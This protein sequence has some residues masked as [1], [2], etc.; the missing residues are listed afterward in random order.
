MR[1]ILLLLLLIELPIFDS[2][3][4]WGYSE[5]ILRRNFREEY[6]E[7]LSKI[8]RFNRIDPKYLRPG[9]KIKI[10]NNIDLLDM[11]SPLPVYVV[12]LK[13][14]KVI[15][16]NL[17]EQWGGA[18]E[19]GVLQFSFPISSAD[20]DCVDDYGRKE[21]CETPEGDFKVLGFD[22]D[23][24]SSLYH[25]PITGENI[26]MPYA[27]L[28]HIKHYK[29]F[30]V[31]YWLHG[32]KLPGYPA[33][34]GCVRLMMEDIKRLF[35]WAGG[36]VK[37]R[38]FIKAKENVFVKV[39]NSP[40]IY[41]NQG[42]LTTLE[43]PY[44]TTKAYFDERELVVF[45][46]DGKKYVLISTNIDERIGKHFLKV[47]Q[48]SELLLEKLIII[49]PTEFSKNISTIWGRY[50]LD[51]EKLERIRK[52]KEAIHQSFENSLNEAL[53]L[54][55]VTFPIEGREGENI[56]RIL[57]RFGEIRLNPVSN[58]SRRHFGIDIKAPEGYP[59]RSIADGRVV[60]TGDHLLEGKVTVIDHGNKVFSLYFHQSE[61]LVSS[62]Y[63]KKGQVIGKVGKTG[64]AYGPHLHLQ[65]RINDIYVD[66][67]KFI[68]LFM[69]AP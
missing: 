37:K 6:A 23:H 56:G 59:L 33:S 25:D 31:S 62:G 19:N 63:V 54:K 12:E 13:D 51:A 1:S 42:D 69:A 46:H 9:M 57:H 5:A 64:N 14:A 67:E 20:Y 26:P 4:R 52:E 10:P 35:V 36:D 58:Y 17:A 3:R 44:L 48:D 43:V 39:Q 49:K 53:W 11:Y 61:I 41:L 65:I 30:S 60:Y 16:L 45:I 28:F 24:Y 40:F 15:L 66:P 50:K 29:N 27:I 22:R 7:N 32:G 38:G 21:Y 34:H 47:Y 8:A 55:G 18:Y 68:S 2:Q